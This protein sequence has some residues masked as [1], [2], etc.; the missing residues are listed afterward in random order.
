MQI[1]NTPIAGLKII[2]LNLFG[3]DRGFF[4]EKFKLSK[5]QEFGLPS[6]FV[7]ENHSKSSPNVIRGLHYQF[8][9]KQGKLVGCT[10][11]K[12]FDVAVDI[13]KDS[14]TLGK[15]FGIILD[16]ATLLWIPPGFAHGFCAIGNENADLYYKITGGEYNP[17]G[18][19]GI[20]WNDPDINIDWNIKNPIISDRDKGQISF[21]EY[22]KDPKF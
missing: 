19:G 1:E 12:I 18:E 9:P 15:Y 17:E 8:N 16:Q 13:R 14:P 11:G 22:L 10:S 5:F 20:M 21:E 6:D 7:Q 2:K 3:D 4:V